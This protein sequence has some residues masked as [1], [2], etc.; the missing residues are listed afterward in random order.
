MRTITYQE[1]VDMLQINKHALDDELEMQA[2]VQ[3]RIHD[4]LQAASNLLEREKDSL[5]RAEA[6]VF[7][8]VTDLHVRSG[9]K[10][11]LDYLRNS[12]KID[13]YRKAKFDSWNAARGEYEV[14]QGLYESWKQRGFALKALTDLAV[15]GYYVT[16]TA[17]QKNRDQIRKK[18]ENQQPRSRRLT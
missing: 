3:Q 18:R 4:R 12:V 8:D 16:D 11:N 1:V 10:P 9:E 14:W 7:I 6:D 13:S 5:E 2:V 17:Y 15:A